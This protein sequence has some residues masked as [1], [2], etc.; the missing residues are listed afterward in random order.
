MPIVGNDSRTGFG[1]LGIE[2]V[3]SLIARGVLIDVAAL[4]GL[5]MLPDSYEVTPQD[6]EKALG[7]QKQILKPGDAVLI[8]TGWGRL[9]N[10]DNARYSKTSPGIVIAA[11]EWL[12]KR[13][14]LLVGADN[15]PVEV[16]PNF[17]RPHRAALSRRARSRPN[18]GRG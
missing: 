12:A 9:W 1:K 10:V 18:A 17:A 7:R 16:S 13:D 3:G 15:G 2:H 4:K 11:A 6:L 5:P 14:Q 8:H